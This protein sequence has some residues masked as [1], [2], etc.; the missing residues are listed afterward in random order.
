MITDIF[1]TSVYTKQIK[2]NNYIKYFK[3]VL[4][5]QKKKNKEGSKIS[6]I[7]G[8]Q[9]NNFKVAPESEITKELFLRPTV[10]F[11]D[12][13]KPKNNN[14]KLYV[15]SWWVNE[16]KTG[17]YN[18]LHNHIGGN[19][20]ILFSGIYYIETPKDCGRLLLLNNDYGKGFDL[21]FNYF[22]DANFMSIYYFLPAKYD[23]IIFPAEKLHMVE[24]NKNIKPRI[25]VAFNIAVLDE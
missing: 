9:T 11:A 4:K 25:S 19:E 3:D 5:Q 6:N 17:D 18:M 23:L 21:G 1:R 10:E 20:K 24:P 12:Q 15:H 13:L 2:N 7:G 22:N 8:Y 14:I 16:N